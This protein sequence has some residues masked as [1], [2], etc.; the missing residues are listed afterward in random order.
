MPESWIFING[1]VILDRF[2]KF[3]W[4]FNSSG[5]CQNCSHISGPSLLCCYCIGVRNG[6]LR[7]RLNLHSLPQLLQSVMADGELLP[8]STVSQCSLMFYCPRSAFVLVMALLK[9][10]IVL[11]YRVVK[12]EISDDNAKL[13]C[14]N[15]RVVSWVS[16]Y[17]AVSVRTLTSYFYPVTRSPTSSGGRDLAYLI[18]VMSL[19]HHMVITMM[20]TTISCFSGTVLWKMDGSGISV[21]LGMPTST[22]HHLPH[23]QE[24]LYLLA[25]SHWRASV[26][27]LLS[28]EKKEKQK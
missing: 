22:S 17:T 13:P 26:K 7:A 12:E 28:G 6:A 5:R 15:G 1:Q 16:R 9:Q 14:F 2:S 18:T 3:L 8:V 27:T 24:H 20:E 19:Q 11:F 4:R 25:V 10:N 21:L 23:V